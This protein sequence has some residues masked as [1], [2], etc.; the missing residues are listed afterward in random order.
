MFDIINERKKFLEESKN[1]VDEF[2]EKKLSPYDFILQIADKKRKYEYDP[3]AAPAF[4]LLQWFSQ[5]YYTVDIVQAI[6]H[7]QFTLKDDIIYKYLF[8]RIP[9]YMKIPKWI[10]KQSSEPK[11]IKELMKKYDVS[12]R[13]AL[14]IFNHQRSINAENKRNQP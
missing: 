1:E 3:K 12:K 11:E 10:K 13:E 8:D 2:E 14:M 7:L 4:I 9:K 6:N 5:N